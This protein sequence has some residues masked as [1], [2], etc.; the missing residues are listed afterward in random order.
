LVLVALLLEDLAYKTQEVTE[1]TLY[2]EPLLLLGAAVEVSEDTQELA[3]PHQDKEVMMEGLE[4]EL[5][6]RVRR[7]PEL[8]DKVTLVGLIMVVGVQVEVLGAAVQ[9]VVAV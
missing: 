7:E 4:E 1:V 9:L 6:H 3:E 8:L 5:A 2:L